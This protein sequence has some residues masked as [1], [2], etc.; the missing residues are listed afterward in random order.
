MQPGR[1]FMYVNA[2]TADFKLKLQVD[3]V[4]RSFFIVTCASARQQ[5]NVEIINE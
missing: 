3:S 5:Q 1:I 2:A 4:A